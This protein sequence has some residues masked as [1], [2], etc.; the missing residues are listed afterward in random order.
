MR[1][2]SKLSMSI[3]GFLLSSSDLFPLVTQVCHQFLPSFSYPFLLMFGY[4]DGVCQRLG[5]RALDELQ[6][7]QWLNLWHGVRG[8]VTASEGVVSFFLFTAGN[9]FY[10]SVIG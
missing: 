4:N 2:F 8:L 10:K 7:G 6:F 1:G 3:Q 9:V 5:L